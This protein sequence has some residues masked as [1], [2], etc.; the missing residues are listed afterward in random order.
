[1]LHGDSGKGTRA[2]IGEYMATR[3]QASSKL[4]IENSS[5]NLERNSQST[6]NKTDNDG[7]SSTERSSG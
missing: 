7:G 1:M 3:Y 2:R 4:E 6:G 5:P